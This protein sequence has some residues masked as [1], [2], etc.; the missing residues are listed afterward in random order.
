MAIQ[1]GEPLGLSLPRP[2]KIDTMR[3]PHQIA[4]PSRRRRANYSGAPLAR[5]P[6]GL[7]RAGGAWAFLLSNFNVWRARGCHDYGAYKHEPYG[8]LDSGTNARDSGLIHLQFDISGHAMRILAL[9]V[10]IVISQGLLT[11]SDAASITL[12]GDPVME[13]HATLEGEIVTGDAQALETLI[14]KESWTQRYYSDEGFVPRLCLH[15]PGGS[16]LEA[17]KL[18][19]VIGS[20]VGTA[21]AEGKTCDSACALVFM[22]G[23][24][25]IVEDASRIS[26]RLHPKGNLGFHAPGLVVDDGVYTKEAVDAA[27][28]VAIKSLYEL[29]KMRTAQG[30]LDIPEDLLSEMLGTPP[31]E[32]RRVYNVNEAIVW[33][34]EIYPVGAP[35][36]IERNDA[37]LNAC[38][39]AMQFLWRRNGAGIYS[40]AGGGD[41]TLRVER[42]A[43]ED[44][45]FTDQ[46]GWLAEGT[47]ECFVKHVK[48]DKSTRYS[49]GAYMGFRS[50]SRDQNPILVDLRD[51]LFF[52]PSMPLK[53]LPVQGRLS[54]AEKFGFLAGEV[55]LTQKVAPR[56][57]PKPSFAVPQ[58]S[59]AAATVPLPETQRML[60]TEDDE[61]LLNLSRDDRREI[62]RRL[63]LLGFD[64]KGADGAFGPNTRAAIMKWQGERNFPP[65]GYL[66]AA[67]RVLLFSDSQES[68]EA[69]Q[70]EEAK[71]PKKRRVRVCQRGP[72][73]LL[74]NCR[75]EWR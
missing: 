26:R 56:N 2:K 33:E 41:F 3:W 45:I 31:E 54:D 75:M 34:I 61:A 40:S 21:I 13:C 30:R 47:F 32:M 42:G 51:I 60:A 23:R 59:P 68:Y 36:K 74:I 29:S 9:I 43:I 22:S 50:G 72:L 55:Q 64:T 27:Y 37:I 70:E 49:P 73:G 67:Q 44:N 10:L 63:T 65:S 20:R 39:N 66:K 69:W 15:S 18:A 17:L 19:E 58:A 57:G 46:G 24:L 38:M 8:L 16:Y 25:H 1:S 5:R 14:Q 62:Q 35:K 6:S 28:K 53:D 4:V 48:A 71:K 7:F 11:A 12:G 52:D